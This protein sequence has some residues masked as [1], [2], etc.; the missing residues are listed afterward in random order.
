MKNIV[1]FDSSDAPWL[2]REAVSVAEAE[3]AIAW[4]RVS[5]SIGS[6]NVV[7]NTYVG[8]GIEVLADVIALN[9]DGTERKPYQA[10]Y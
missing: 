6:K 7:N 9:S 1:L 10:A 5:G 4:A 2:V 3:N 8:G